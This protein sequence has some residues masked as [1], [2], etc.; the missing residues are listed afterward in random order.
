MN[1]TEHGPDAF[2]YVQCN[3]FWDRLQEIMIPNWS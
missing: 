3:A 2:T 1:P